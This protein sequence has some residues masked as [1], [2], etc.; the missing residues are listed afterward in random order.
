MRV[1][2]RGKSA[3][4][5]SSSTSAVTAS[6]T[7]SEPKLSFVERYNQALSRP[8]VMSYRLVGQRI[9]RVIPLFE[10]LRP[11]LLRSGKRIH[12]EAYV[13][14]IAFTSVIAFAVGFAITAF[15]V[16]ALHGELL[17]VLLLGLG[18]GLLSGAIGFAT[19][20]ALPGI[21]A[22]SRK[23]SMDEEL[24]YSMSHMA[25]LA[26]AGLPPE[27]VFRSLAESEDKSVVAE[28]SKMVIRDI[29]MLGFD[30]LTALANARE[31]SPSKAFS[32]FLEGFIAA[33]R[34]GGD[35]KKY[36]MSSAKEIMELRRIAAK[37]LV[38]TLGMIAEAYVSVLVVF[39]LILLIMFS[40][41]GLVGGGIGGFS[42]F[43]IMALVTYAMIPLLAVMMILLLDAMLP[44]R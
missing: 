15:I 9:A 32:D 16:L 11:N 43:S 18:L 7:L 34:S 40:V 37:Q 8:W 31:R 2:R 6:S 24:P 29:D 10:D 13:S 41:M 35:L 19:M 28:E 3:E 20:Y 23:R 25:V 21:G 36:L 33:T 17:L 42:V 4:T 1:F 22:D 38:D 27:R 44:K 12:F 26:A 14:L 39:P 30:V 5:E